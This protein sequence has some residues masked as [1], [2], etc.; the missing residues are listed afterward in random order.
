MKGN[1][2]GFFRLRRE[3]LELRLRRPMPKP[4]LH[5]SD[6]SDHHGEIYF[7][8]RSY[9]FA[10]NS[11]SMRKLFNQRF[12][13]SLRKSLKT[14]P[15]YSRVHYSAIRAFQ[16][17]QGQKEPKYT[18]VINSVKLNLVD[19]RLMYFIQ[20]RTTEKLMFSSPQFP[21]FKQ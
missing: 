21:F 17:L 5:L 6:K 14:G 16:A 10:G 7:P 13:A 1:V 4:L 8:D 20:S 18:P 15:C 3:I 12:P 2:C 11:S 19:K 9:S